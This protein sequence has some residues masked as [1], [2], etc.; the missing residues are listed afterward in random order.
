MIIN[1]TQHNATPEQLK[2]GVV[3]IIS[4]SQRNHVLTFTS[5]PT[6]E[7]IRHRANDIARMVSR[8]AGRGCAVMIGGAPFFMGALEA[9]LKEAGFKP[10]YAFSERKSV[11]VVKEDGSVVK[12]AVFVHKGFVEV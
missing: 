2:A 5:L 7:Y 4:L 8:V 11:D 1:L 12:T 6:A 10:V 9:A 3:D